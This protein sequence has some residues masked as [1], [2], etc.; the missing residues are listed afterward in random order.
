MPDGLKAGAGAMI[1]AII[2]AAGREPD[3]VIGKPEPG[4]MRE[5]AAVA[6]VP[7]E[8]AVVIGDGLVT[9]IAAANAVGARSVL[10]L[11]GVSTSEQALALPVEQQPTVIAQGPSDLGDVLDRLAVA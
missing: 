1:Q 2:T 3:I 10:V 7:V 9:D 5:A 6:G 11:T 8:E 4:L